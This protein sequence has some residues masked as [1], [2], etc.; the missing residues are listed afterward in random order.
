MTDRE[1]ALG[2]LLGDCLYEDFLQVLHQ[3]GFA[4]R[5]HSINECYV[6][7]VEIMADLPYPEFRHEYLGNF[8]VQGDEIHLY[9]EHEYIPTGKRT[10]LRE[11]AD[12]KL[13]EHVL[14]Y[15]GKE[16]WEIDVYFDNRRHHEDFLRAAKMPPDGVEGCG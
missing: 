3:N 15:F 1:A 2:I 11:L 10:V 7:S 6:F 9:K 16:Q 5:M 12:P 13:H 8:K 14:K 4:T